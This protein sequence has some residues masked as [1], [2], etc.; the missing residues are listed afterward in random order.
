MFE[1]EIS[2]LLHIH[3]G[4]RVRL[5]KYLPS[6]YI[7]PWF[8]IEFSRIITFFCEQLHTFICN[9]RI[10]DDLFHVPLS[11]HLNHIIRSLEPH[12]ILTLLL[13]GIILWYYTIIRISFHPSW[14]YPTHRIYQIV[15]ELLHL[16]MVL[17]HR[18]D[19]IHGTTPWASILLLYGHP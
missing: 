4:C 12:T 14:Y 7:C 8:Y 19:I 18:Q 1:G 10:S 11:T 17:L 2:T 13:H 15:V 3:A 5:S 16:A 9:V 6:L